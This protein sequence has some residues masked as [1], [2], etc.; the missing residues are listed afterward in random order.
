MLY[1]TVLRHI[2][3]VALC[4]CA[5]YPAS[6][7]SVSGRLRRSHCPGCDVPFR[8]SPRRSRPLRG[9][10][11]RPTAPSSGSLSRGDHE[12]F[13]IKLK[14]VVRQVFGSTYGS[15][16]PVQNSQGAMSRGLAARHA[17]QAARRPVSFSSSQVNICFLPVEF[18]VLTTCG[19]PSPANTSVTSR[20]Y[21]LAR[22]LPDVGR[23]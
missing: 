15:P 8:E 20:T 18:R 11:A 21:S 5:R 2:F 6:A 9:Y 23:P 22:K 17:S 10:R 1:P 7:G 13:Q 16:S 4:Q 19:R 12:A 14:L 3:D